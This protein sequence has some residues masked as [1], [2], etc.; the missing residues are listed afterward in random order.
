MRGLLGVCVDKARRRAGLP[1]GYSGDARIEGAVTRRRRKE[2]EGR[3]G[4]GCSRAAH[5]KE[6]SRSRTGGRRS[7]RRAARSKLRT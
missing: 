5:R 3:G 7:L 1:N 6:W 4:G 2:G